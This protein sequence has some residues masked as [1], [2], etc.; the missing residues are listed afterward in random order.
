MGDLTFSYLALFIV[1]GLLGFAGGWFV[2]ALSQQ[3]YMDDL[4]S[5]VGSLRAA[6]EQARTRRDLV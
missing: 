4:Q 2:R 5:D 6:I 1:A 3:R